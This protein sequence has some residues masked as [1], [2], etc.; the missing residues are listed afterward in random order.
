M[1][2]YTVDL[3]TYNLSNV[4]IDLILKITLWRNLKGSQVAKMIIP[5]PLNYP[6][7]QTGISDIV[8]LKGLFEAELNVI[9]D[10]NM[11][12]YYYPMSSI[13]NNI[14]RVVVLNKFYNVSKS[15]NLEITPEENFIFA[16]LGKR[17]ICISFPYILK[18]FNIDSNVTP[19][20]LQASGGAIRIDNDRYR[21]RKYLMSGRLNI[22][23]VY[24]SKYKKDFTDSKFLFDKYSDQELAEA[25]V[26]LENN[27]R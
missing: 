6:L 13:G 16:G 8:K 18:Y 12:W 24:Q 5:L 3:G 27:E 4:D 23:Q 26:S 22:L 11:S 1:E 25:L 14:K 10:K 19:I 20:V 15:E 7:T 9:T 2:S 21:V 17:F